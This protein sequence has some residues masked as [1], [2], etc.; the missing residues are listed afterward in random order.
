PT[1]RGRLYKTTDMGL[2]WTAHQVTNLTDFGGTAQSATVT[3]S[4]ATNGYLLKTAGTTYTYMTSVDGGVNW[5]APLSFSGTRRIVKYIPGTNVLVATSQAAPVGTSV[6]INN[7]ATWQSVETAE[8][9]GASDFLDMTTGWCAGFSQ[10]PFDGGIFKLTG[11][12][13]NSVV[14]AAKFTV[15]PNPANSIVTISTPEVDSANLSVSDLS[16]KVVMTKSLS[17]IENTVDIS[18]LS[19][20]AYFFEVSSDSKKEVI[21]ILKN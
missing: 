13:A 7:G 6:S 19:T 15:Y 2:T 16:G 1:N 5:S 21:K 18:N 20:G 11:T 10:G 4:N 12:L 17:G 14:N 3:F 8:Q 9:R